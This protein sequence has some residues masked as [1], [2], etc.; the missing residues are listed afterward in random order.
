MTNS[1]DQ[2][3]TDWSKD[4]VVD[5]DDLFPDDGEGDDNND[6]NGKSKNKSS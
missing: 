5:E 6:G 3:D 4:A 1:Y 2:A